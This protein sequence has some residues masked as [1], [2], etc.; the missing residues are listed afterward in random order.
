MLMIC[1]LL[2]NCSNQQEQVV[3]S[4]QVVEEDPGD[5]LYTNSTIIIQPTQSQL[6]SL[7]QKVRSSDFNIGQD[8]YVFY[9][10]AM[11]GFFLD[12]NVVNYTFSGVH[13]LKYKNAEG[14]VVKYDLE[15]NGELWQL[16]FFSPQKGFQ[17]IDFSDYES[18]F[19]KFFDQ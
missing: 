15:Q 2:T 12:K 14:K 10:N 19:K 17:R 9:A 3:V 11:S 16:Y 13:S 8:D 5:V 1:F 4:S 7:Q 18:A 6:D